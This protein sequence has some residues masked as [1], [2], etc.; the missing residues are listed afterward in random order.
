MLIAHP[1]EMIPAVQETVAQ[2][3]AQSLPKELI[4]HH[5]RVD[6]FTLGLSGVNNRKVAKLMMLKT[7]A[8]S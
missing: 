8:I 6:H 4:S 1:R 5:A 3:V 2:V 7:I